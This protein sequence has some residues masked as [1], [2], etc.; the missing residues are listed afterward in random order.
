MIKGGWFNLLFE[1][2]GRWLLIK[3]IFI[4]FLYI[5]HFS[6]HVIFKQQVKGIFRYTSQQLRIW[7]EVATIFLIA[8]VMLATVKENMSVVWGLVGLLLFI[9]LL[10]SAIKIYKMLRK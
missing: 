8:I 6:L 7:N 10:M 9:V 2:A 1:P 4:F 5:Y 3:L